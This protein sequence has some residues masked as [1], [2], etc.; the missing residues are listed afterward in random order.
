MR[1]N[2]LL[3]TTAQASANSLI[4]R[5]LRYRSQV[6]HKAGGPSAYTHKLVGYLYQDT[7]SV[8]LKLLHDSQGDF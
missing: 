5:G 3:I 4:L 7:V 1:M 8:G 6:I 2:K